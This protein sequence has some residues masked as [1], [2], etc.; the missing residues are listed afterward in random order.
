MIFRKNVKKGGGVISDLKNSLQIWCGL[1]RFGKK[2][3]YFFPKKGR[4][5]RGVKGRSEIFRKFI[6]IGKDG[7]PLV[8]H[9][10]SFRFPPLLKESVTKSQS[11]LFVLV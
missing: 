7:L 3:Q 2:S 1:V 4:G 11:A 9:C 6:D 10:Y 5:G 8:L